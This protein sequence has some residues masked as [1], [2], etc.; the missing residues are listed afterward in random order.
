M[1]PD[2]ALVL[3]LVL[4]K[5]YLFDRNMKEVVGLLRFALVGWGL[6]FWLLGVRK[7]WGDGPG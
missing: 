5:V 2:E 7:G 3:A 1:A 4:K 6:R